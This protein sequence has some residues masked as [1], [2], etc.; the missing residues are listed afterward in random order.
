MQTEKMLQYIYHILEKQF[1]IYVYSGLFSI[2]KK[3]SDSCLHDRSSCLREKEA[4]LT[5]PPDPS[6]SGFSPL[7][8]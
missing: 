1:I 7:V 4:S 2:A 8:A 3:R 6:Y 5:V